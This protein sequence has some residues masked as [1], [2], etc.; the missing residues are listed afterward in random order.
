MAN[1]SQTAEEQPEKTTITEY[2][3]LGVG[4]LLAAIV[5]IFTVQNVA[6]A[7]I[8][9]LVWTINLSL[10]LLIIGVLA[11]GICTGWLVTSWFNLKRTRAVHRA[12][13]GK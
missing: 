10:S 5:V 3:K 11:V 4:I 6:A 7:E 1:Q 8:R 12:L 13:K 2:I 9:F